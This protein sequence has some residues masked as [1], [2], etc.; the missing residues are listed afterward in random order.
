MLTIGCVSEDKKV[1]VVAG[2][3]F[4]GIAGV[5]V[6]LAVNAIYESFNEYADRKV[7]YFNSLFDK[8]SNHIKGEIKDLAFDKIKDFQDKNDSEDQ[9]NI[10]KLQNFYYLASHNVKERKFIIRKFQD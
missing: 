8:D 4:F 9:A 5:F 3:V 2:A 10:F 1:N 6:S 7:V